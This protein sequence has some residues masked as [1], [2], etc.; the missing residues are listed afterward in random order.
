VDKNIKCAAFEISAGGATGLD[1]RNGPALARARLG[2]AVV[3]QAAAF[4]SR[5]T[6]D[7]CHTPPLAVLKPRSVRAVAMASRVLP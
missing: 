7:L 1:G 4:N 3:A 5:D 2:E 6:V